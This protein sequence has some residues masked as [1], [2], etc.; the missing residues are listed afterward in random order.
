M[1]AHHAQVGRSQCPGRLHKLPLFH[2]HHLGAH[3]P[4]V[5]HPAGDRERENQIEQTRAKECDECN[6]EQNTGQRQECIGHVHVQHG[7]CPSSV[8][9]GR[10]TRDQPHRQGD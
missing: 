2:C 1:R 5:S 7:V 10:K 8:E 3:Q 9:A 6:G 4:R